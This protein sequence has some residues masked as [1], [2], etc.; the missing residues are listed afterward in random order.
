[1]KNEGRDPKKMPLAKRFGGCIRYTK[2][3]AIEDEGL[4]SWVV[5]ADIYQREDADKNEEVST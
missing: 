4:L 3:W 2:T 1:V 5:E